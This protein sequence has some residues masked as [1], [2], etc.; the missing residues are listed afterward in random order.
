M[1]SLS[2]VILAVALP[3]VSAFPQTPAQQTPSQVPPVPPTSTQ[4]APSPQRPITQPLQ[5]PSPPTP[6]VAPLTLQQALDMAQ[7]R[8]GD[9]AAEHFNVGAADAS[10]KQALGAF[11]PTITPEFN[12]SDQRRTGNVSQFGGSA[13][14]GTGS[15]T[16]SRGTSINSGSTADV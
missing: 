3:V 7:K 12:Y 16:A 8:N 5:T 1:R 11:F 2:I 15:S 14:G 10:V 9:V 4:P 6:A 13:G